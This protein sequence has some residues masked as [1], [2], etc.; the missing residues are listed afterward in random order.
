MELCSS[1][2]WQGEGF[3]DKNASIFVLNLK[4]NVYIANFT[5]QVFS[6]YSLIFSASYYGTSNCPNMYM[7]KL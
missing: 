6:K 7:R 2:A 1:R 3:V 5:G 4:I